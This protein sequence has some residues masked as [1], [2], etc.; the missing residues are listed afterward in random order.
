MAPERVLSIV[1]QFYLQHA[2]LLDKAEREKARAAKA[3]VA[4]ADAERKER[5]DLIDEAR[6]EARETPRAR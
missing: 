2:K 6:K 1:R 5:H 3:F 4:A